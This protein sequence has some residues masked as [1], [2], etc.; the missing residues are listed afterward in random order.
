MCASSSSSFASSLQGHLV[1]VCHACSAAEA[2]Q[3][4]P[5]GPRGPVIA[6]GCRAAR[7]GSCWACLQHADS[8]GAAVR[9]PT[10]LTLP[11]LLPG[12]RETPWARSRW[13]CPGSAWCAWKAV[14][15]ESCRGSPSALLCPVH[16]PLAFHGVAVPQFN[17]VAIA[18][19]LDCLT[20][21]CV[22]CMEMCTIVA[23]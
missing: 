13:R 10:P 23:C 12:G 18:G 9:A 8:V 3:C 14:S 16:R 15:A 21:L 2:P 1:A 22:V 6:V 7:A 20:A 5:E 11:A 4:R 19:Y 17:S